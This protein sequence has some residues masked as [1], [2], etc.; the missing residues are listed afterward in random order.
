M[1]G[2]IGASFRHRDFQLFD[3]ESLAANRR[4]R[5]ID[6]AITLRRHAQQFD[7]AGWIKRFQP[8]PYM[9]R[10]PQ[11]ERRF[12]RRDHEATR[13][14]EMIHQGAAMPASVTRDG[15]REKWVVKNSSIEAIRAPFDGGFDVSTRRSTLVSTCS[16]PAAKPAGDRKSLARSGQH[17]VHEPIGKKC[18]QR[19]S[20][21][22]RVHFFA[23]R[24][25]QPQGAAIVRLPARVQVHDD[26]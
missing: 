17:F 22:H 21:R 7:H 18:R 9:L 1:N 13:R 15:A 8:R 12:T 10:L 19:A 23:G 24:Q 6:H 20:L 25:M 14:M 16:G 26:R 5:A 2:Q 3:E 4:E 11:R